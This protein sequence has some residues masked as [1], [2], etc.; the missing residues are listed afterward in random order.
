VLRKDSV[1]G[2]RERRNPI[3]N[4]IGL[5]DV[6]LNLGEVFCPIDFISRD[7]PQGEN[8]DTAPFARSQK[9]SC[10]K[11]VL[12]DAEPVATA[13]AMQKIQDESISEKIR[14]LLFEPRVG[15]FDSAVTPMPA[16]KSDNAYRI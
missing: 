3:I 11:S 12:L 2:T 5:S 16:T 15:L 6:I 10:S 14:K 8:D 7:I 13:Q 4:R 9:S 1:V